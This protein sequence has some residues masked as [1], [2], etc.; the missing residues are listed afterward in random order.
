MN[1]K[2]ARNLRKL[3]ERN[4]NIPAKVYEEVKHNER[5]MQVGLT[6]EGKP[7][8][9]PHTPVTIELGECQRHYYQ[10]AK[11]LHHLYQG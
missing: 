9:V 2:Q 4:S 8:Y 3:I 5:L 10:R 7:N 1:G 11:K 6:A